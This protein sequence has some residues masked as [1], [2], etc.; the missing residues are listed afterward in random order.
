MGDAANATA[1]IAYLQ[2]VY[3]NG[4]SAS[5]AVRCYLGTSVVSEYAGGIA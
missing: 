3:V 5:V 4:Y 2:S 1:C